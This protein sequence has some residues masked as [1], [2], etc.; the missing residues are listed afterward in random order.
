MGIQR[1]NVKQNDAGEDDEAGMTQE[2]FEMGQEK[3]SGGEEGEGGM[4]K[5]EVVAPGDEFM[6]VK[7]WLGA[8]KAPSGYTKPAPNHD[9]KPNVGLEL[10]YCYGY[11]SK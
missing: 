4:F 2:E 10:E 5:E 1:K 7:P 9:K 8:I 3:E 11:R 6:A